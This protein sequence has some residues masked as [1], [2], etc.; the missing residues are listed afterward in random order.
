MK[1]LW[2]GGWAIPTDWMQV[3]V[4]RAFP[5]LNNICIHPHQGFLNAIHEFRPEIL[6]GYSLGATL[7]LMENRAIF[8]VS[9]TYLIAP[10]VNLKD[11]IFIDTTQVKFL[12][13]WIKRDPMGAINDFYDRAQ[14]SL[15]KGSS[16]PYPFEDL[17]W[18]LEVLIQ[19]P[20]VSSIRFDKTIFLG[21]RD[22]LIN[23]HFFLEHFG[24]TRLLPRSNHNLESYLTPTELSF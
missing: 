24:D 17:V 13:K 7:L 10:F 18:G 22:P 12:L 8:S 23:P 5:G 19:R 15:P 11:A 14:L 16:L 1:V 21:G 4:N 2:L 20:E 9:R 6:V 3:Q